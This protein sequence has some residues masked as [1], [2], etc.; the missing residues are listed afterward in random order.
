MLCYVM[1]VEVSV[2]TLEGLQHH[3]VLGAMPLLKVCLEPG[4][5][6][7]V[8]TAH[9]TQEPLQY[10]TFY[11]L[12]S[13]GGGGGGATPTSPYTTLQHNKGREV[14]VRATFNT[15]HACYAPTL[16]NELKKIHKYIKDQSI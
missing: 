16:P 12:H 9:W 14:P 1:L 11:H 5:R 4:H 8:K 2:L 7:T 13:G 6:G 15:R 10:L 3:M